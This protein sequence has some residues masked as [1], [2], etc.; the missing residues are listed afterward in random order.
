VNVRAGLVFPLRAQDVASAHQEAPRCSRR[1]CTCFRRPCS[2]PHDVPDPR[3]S[4]AEGTC[5]FR[6]NA[7][8]PERSR[9]RLSEGRALPTP[10]WPCWSSFTA[11][12]SLRAVPKRGARADRRLHYPITTRRL[13]AP[14]LTGRRSARHGDRESPQGAERRP[15]QGTRSRAHR[16]LPLPA[17]RP[18]AA[19]GGAKPT[20]ATRG[21]RRRLGCPGVYRETPA[22][23]TAGY[24]GIDA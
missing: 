9:H 5:S 6:R 12:K 1:T 23:G 21:F 10:R 3:G 19:V 22:I 24:D 2:A 13:N 17:R 11:G 16:V 15:T 4:F 8:R 20:E 14:P 7:R 18:C